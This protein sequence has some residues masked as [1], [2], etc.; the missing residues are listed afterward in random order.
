VKNSSLKPERR[1]PTSSADFR[2]GAA[3]RVAIAVYSGS[4][5]ELNLIAADRCNPSSKSSD[6]KG[7]NTGERLGV[8]EAGFRLVVIYQTGLLKNAPLL[9][10]T[11]RRSR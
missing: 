11:A 7:G 3:R 6:W 2:I 4:R 9:P 5:I 10:A 1:R 8:F